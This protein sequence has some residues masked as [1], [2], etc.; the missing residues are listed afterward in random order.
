[1]TN[2]EFQ[3]FTILRQ[4]YGWHGHEGT[5]NSKIDPKKLQFI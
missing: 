4:G 3:A 1:M 2:S 5:K